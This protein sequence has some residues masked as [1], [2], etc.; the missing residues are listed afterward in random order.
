MLGK[1]LVEETRGIM[2]NYFSNDFP[3]RVIFSPSASIALNQII[4]GVS[5][6]SNIYFTPFEHNSI[7]RPI[8]HLKQQ[9]P[10]LNLIEIPF[11]N[12]SFKIDWRKL[13][14]R[15]ENF[16]PDLLCLTQT[17]NVTGFMPPLDKIISLALEYNP[18]ALVLVDGAQVAGFYPLA[19]EELGIDYYVF[20]GHKS[21]LAGYGVAGWVMSE[22]GE[23][24]LKP[25]LFGGTGTE[26]E[27]LSMP[28]SV[29]SRFEV[30]SMNIWAIA[31]LNAA[32]KWLNKQNLG[33]LRQITKKNGLI[34]A[35]FLE[36]RTGVKTFIPPKDQWYPIISF[37]FEKS[38]SNVIGDILS[39]RGVANRSGFHCA[40]LAHRWIGSDSNGGTIRLSPG[41]FTQE[42]EI[43]M[44]LSILENTF[45]EVENSEI[46]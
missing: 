44:A 3:N 24:N 45:A 10:L 41:P 20:S 1:R 27:Q 6:I 32:L 43:E 4:F 17:S 14:D 23:K 8:Y 5:N 40:P 35:E 42:D 15:F 19:I 30:G 28:K 34:L 22:K 46:P 38:L 21:F 18:E 31:S 2:A 26:S 33:L 16:P 13:E 37:V 29:P 39:N 12:P 7:L 9:N 36:K 11:H 25:F